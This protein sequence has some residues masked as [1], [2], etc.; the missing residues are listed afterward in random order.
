MSKSKMLAH[1]IA[2]LCAVLGFYLIYKISCHL[3]LPGQKYVTPV[4]YARWLWA[5]NDWFFR[6][7]IVMNFFIKPFFIYYL[8]WNLLELRFR[9]RH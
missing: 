3:I 5:T 9:K 8:I 6:L 4:L 2:L 1:L 7:L